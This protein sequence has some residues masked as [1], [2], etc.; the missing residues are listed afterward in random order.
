MVKTYKKGD[1]TIRYD[2][3]RTPGHTKMVATWDNDAKARAAQKREAEK[4]RREEAAKRKAEAKRISRLKP[5][6][7]RKKK[8]R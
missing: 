5:S 6:A 3:T 7:A 1:T 2:T 4:G 8:K